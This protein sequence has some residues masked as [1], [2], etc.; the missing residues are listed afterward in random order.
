MLWNYWP[1][2]FL[3]LIEIGTNCT[4]ED[5]QKCCMKNM[6]LNLT[7]KHL[8]RS[9][10]FNLQSTTLRK[11]KLLH[12]CFSV[13]FPESLRTTLLSNNCERLLFYKT[14]LPSA[15]FKMAFKTLITALV[16]Y[17][18]I[19]RILNNMKVSISWN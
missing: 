8:Y 9:H 6:F 18:F 19:E 10:F 11:K 2:L 14:F 4:P 15:V 12:K 3:A 1:C 5:A 7:E 13:S 17:S 16:V